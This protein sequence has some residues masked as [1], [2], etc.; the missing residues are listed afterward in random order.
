MV[1]LPNS[2]AKEYGESGLILFFLYIFFL[3]FV[4]LVT[5]LLL[6]LYQTKPEVHNM[7]LFDT[8]LFFFYPFPIV[9]DPKMMIYPLQF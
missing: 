3:I 7:F 9:A 4:D 6:E 8:K 2:F 5:R 1:R